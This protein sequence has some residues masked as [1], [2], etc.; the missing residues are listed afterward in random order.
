MT[1]GFNVNFVGTQSGVADGTPANTNF[2][3]NH[4]GHPGWMTQDALDNIDAIAA[5]TQ[6]DI[7]L[8]DLGSNDIE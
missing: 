4:E 7:V 6:P 8:I 1:A 3:Q 2:D 5:T